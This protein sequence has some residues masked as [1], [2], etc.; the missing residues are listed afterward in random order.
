MAV[1]IDWKSR[2][3]NEIT[4]VENGGSYAIMTSEKYRRI[5]QDLTDAQK[6]PLSKTSTQYRQLKKYDLL[7]VAGVKKLIA[8]SQDKEKFLYYVPAEELFDVIKRAHEACG[9]G[10]RDRVFKEAGLEYAN[11][12]RQ[13]ICLFLSMCETCQQKKPKKRRGLVSKPI[14]H[15]QM[16]S[17][18]QVDL[19]DLQTQPDGDYKF[20]MVYQDH[21]TK[22]VILRALKTK[23]AEEVA[24]QLK[25]IFS[26][27]GAPCIFHTDN[28]RE[29]KNK[30]V[31]E[32]AMLWPEVRI[33][34]G[35]PR[36]SQTQG[37]VE[38]CNQ[39]IENMLAA[40][41]KENKNK[42]WTS[43]LQ[44]VQIMKNRAYHSG[45]QQ[46]PYMKSSYCAI[47][48]NVKRNRY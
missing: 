28:G 32:L 16:N 9:H 24:V 47:R 33:V 5:I 42:S 25:D 8:K 48:L 21:L 38:K 12:T 31:E 45:I 34:H 1:G 39:D 2:F 20:I 15:K 3:F 11:V 46:S 22:F 29:F 13:S 10:G 41:L 30:I 27:F 26:I 19:I 18:C 14:I 43:G 6:N 4:S 40:W 44:D 17:R 36:H 35:K 23:S 7:E 37:S